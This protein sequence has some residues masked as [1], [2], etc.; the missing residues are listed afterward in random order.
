MSKNTHY[1][2]IILVDQNLS[3][4]M[5]ILSLIQYLNPIKFLATV[6]IFIVLSSGCNPNEADAKK[7]MRENETFSPTSTSARFVKLE[8]NNETFVTNMKNSRQRHVATVLLNGKLLVTGGT[9]EFGTSPLAEIYDPL[10]NIWTPLT[11]MR[12]ARTL[13][14]ATLLPNG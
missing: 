1:H 5:N 10:T 3:Q 2:W 12:Y 7:D 8:A 4:K 14:S 6:A 11:A 9:D 13:H